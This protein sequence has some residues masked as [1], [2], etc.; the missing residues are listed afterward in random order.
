LLILSRWPA[1]PLKTLISGGHVDNA[2]IRIHYWYPSCPYTPQKGGRVDVFAQAL[3][4]GLAQG[5]VYAL[6]AIGFVIIYK[7]T[8]VP[9][10]A[11]GEITMVGAY[12]YFSFVTILGFPAFWALAATLVL[13]GLLGAL[14]ERTV[15]N[16]IS[17]EPP[18]I[19]IMATIG[20]AILLRGFTGIIWSHDTHAFPSPIPDRTFDVAGVVISSADLS[21]FSL[22]VVVTLLL[23]VFFHWTRIGIAMRA[24]AQNRYA[25]QL[26]G[27]SVQRIFTLSWVLAAAVG[28]LGGI[29]LADLN[30]LHT[31]MGTIIMV[32][33]VAAVVGG[34]ESI[35]GAL[36]GGLFIGV[37]ANL[38]GTY[39]DWFLGGGAKDVAA[40]AVLLIVLLIRPYGF[41]G[42]PDKKRV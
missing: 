6:V 41:F 24:V 18:F 16:P 7:A 38:S 23:F 27:I 14:I 17:D 33:I 15:I 32:G 28:A 40:F 20:L 4:S 9:N 36:L 12:I 5:C 21:A 13:A 2:T 30:Y 19:A 25:A 34:L 29:V 10:F 26:M 37:V 11:Q 3:V 35:P 1:K 31:N 22:V 42:I 39:L 8:E